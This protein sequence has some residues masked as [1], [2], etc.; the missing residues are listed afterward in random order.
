MTR[1]RKPGRTAK[2][3]GRERRRRRGASKAAHAER[4][5]GRVMAEVGD[6]IAG[7]RP[8]D[9]A[10]RGVVED[11]LVAGAQADVVAPDLIAATDGVDE[12]N[13]QAVRRDGCFGYVGGDDLVGAL[14]DLPVASRA[15]GG[16]DCLAKRRLRRRE[17]EEPEPEH[18]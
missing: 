17:R 3:A 8:G 2:V 14:R 5:R 6:A 1:V 12:S 13:P 18:Q 4:G 7:G 10:H 16:I 11:E 9:G 15:H